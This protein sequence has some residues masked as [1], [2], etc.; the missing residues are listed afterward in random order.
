[1]NILPGWLFGYQLGIAW[2]RGR[3]RRAGW[4]VLLVGAATFALLLVDLGY[5]ASMVGIPGVDRSNANPPS[6]LVVALAAT[7]AGIAIVPA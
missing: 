3:L 7:Q 5:P 2:A 1:M 4:P 6:L